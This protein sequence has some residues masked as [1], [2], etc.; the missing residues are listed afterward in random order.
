MV[1]QTRNFH[2]LKPESDIETPNAAELEERVAIALAGDGSVDP[3]DIVVVDVDGDIYLRGTVSSSIEVARA[4]DVAR[5]I[6]G[7]KSVV[8]ELAIVIGQG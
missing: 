5:S 7:V 4:A 6:E 8:N 3:S 2:G 1:M